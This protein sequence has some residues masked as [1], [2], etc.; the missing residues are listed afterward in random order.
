MI[1]GA[2]LAALG[3]LIGLPTQ[4]TYLWHLWTTDGLNSIGILIPL[5]CI[6]LCLR[7]WRG[8][9]WGTDSTWWGFV[10]IAGVLAISLAS[11]YGGMAFARGP[12]SADRINLFPAGVMIFAYVS[13]A[14]LFLGG[15]EA[16]KQARFGLLLLLLVN[17]VPHIF[18]NLIDLPLQFI[19]ASIA[20]G[21]AA[22]LVIALIGDRL[23]LLFEPQLGMF[24]AP[25]CN[26]LRGSVAMGLLALIFGHLRGLKWL[27]L[28][29]FTGCAVA[30][31][32]LFNLLRLCTLVLAYKVALAMP[33]L[34]PHLLAVDYLI[35]GVLFVT[36]VLFVF[37]APK[38]FTSRH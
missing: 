9:E 23:H 24:I 34:G 20:R 18:R 19:A 32:Y 6:W 2:G 31:A 35:G 1:L 11:R 30:L 37:E 26:G 28:L 5:L 4:L 14:V 7:A 13:G 22:W 33:Q 8:R 29:I 25:G 15:I 3:L 12:S 16:W 27:P 17:P 38:V 36:A 10:L 21:F